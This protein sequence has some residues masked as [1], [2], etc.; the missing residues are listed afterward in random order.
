MWQWGCAGP[1]EVRKWGG[2]VVWVI[3]SEYRFCHMDGWGWCGVVKVKLLNRSGFRKKPWVAAISRKVWIPGK[4]KLTDTRYSE[5][6]SSSAARTQELEALGEKTNDSVL[7]SSAWKCFHNCPLRAVIMA[8]WVSL[9]NLKYEVLACQLKLFPSVSWKALFVWSMYFLCCLC[10]FTYHSVSFCFSSNMCVRC[11][12]NFFNT[13][14]LIVKAHINSLRGV[15]R[16]SQVTRG[17]SHRA[18]IQSGMHP[19]VQDRWR[20]QWVKFVL[21]PSKKGGW[22]KKRLFPN[23]DT[24][25]SNMGF[26]LTEHKFNRESKTFIWKK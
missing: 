7:R 18:S 9:I 13:G 25:G 24:V 6:R 19:C 12:I 26:V 11:H 4:H 21:K 23:K 10:V 5:M 15:R 1:R 16:N 17:S 22:Y 8:F 3:G 20:C 14:D 2:V